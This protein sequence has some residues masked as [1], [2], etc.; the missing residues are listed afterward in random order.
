MQEKIKKKNAK[1]PYYDVKKKKNYYCNKKGK[2]KSLQTYNPKLSNFN[3][4]LVIK[5]FTEI[6]NK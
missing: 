1:K 3:Y 5:G 4:N 6:C 2:I